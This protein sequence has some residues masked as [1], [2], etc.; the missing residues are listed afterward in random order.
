MLARHAPYPAS[1]EVETMKN[2]LRNSVTA[3]WMGWI[4]LGMMANANEPDAK[5]KFFVCVHNYARV[6]SHIVR[7]A[8][9]VA[10][11][12]FDQAGVDTTWED[13]IPSSSDAE[14]SREGTF[15]HCES[16]LPI[17]DVNLL[18]HHGSFSLGDNVL[19]LAAGA[20]EDG[21][22]TVYV[23]E[24]VAD[25]L[26]ESQHFVVRSQILGHAMAHEI[27]HILAHVIRHYTTGL[28]KARW[29]TEDFRAMAQ[30]RLN[31][32]AE[33]A[34]RIREEVIQRTRQHALLQIAAT[35]QENK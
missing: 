24:K 1:K 5:P 20:D 26:T 11:Q 9:K 21:A 7:A 34:A 2:A 4:G 29:E 22:R 12:I 25:D 17:M 6:S 31:F 16:T 19:G 32:N 23:F 18:D 30:L 8:E 13:F 28:M 15:F 10:K 27:G 14:L 35:S 33:Q 3:I